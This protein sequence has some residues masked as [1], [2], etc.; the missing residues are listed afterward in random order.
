MIQSGVN[1]AVT[2]EVVNRYNF[3]LNSHRAD[4]YNYDTPACE[5]RLNQQISLSE[6]G[7]QF[8]VYISTC[9]IPYTFYQFSAARESS[10]V[11]WIIT[12]GG[13]GSN[14]VVIP[15]GNYNITQ[16]AGAFTS[17]FQ[18]QLIAAGFPNATVT[19]QY[20]V[21]SN[22]IRFSLL[23]TTPLDI[24]VNPTNSSGLMRAFGF[25]SPFTLSTTVAFVSGTADCNIMPVNMLYITSQTLAGSDSYEQL[26]TQNTSSLII[27]NIPIIHSARYYL[28]FEP[29]HPIRTRLTNTTLSSI[30]FTIIDNFGFEIENFPVAWSLTLI[31]EEIRIKSM[32]GIDAVHPR[33]GLQIPVQTA[34]GTLE[35]RDPVERQIAK[36]EETALEKI[37][38]IEDKLKESNIKKRKNV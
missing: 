24:L 11:E 37:N 19:S 17:M 10:S 35:E 32:F 33:F 34:D 26:R 8:E 1:N 22:R 16:L 3:Y 7:T 12:S 25:Y 30:D 2:G 20:N 13:S 38:E 31:I 9:M 18:Q 15:D 28:P 21:A 29:N 14:T 6:P 36:M 23:N 5:F 4:E 27:A